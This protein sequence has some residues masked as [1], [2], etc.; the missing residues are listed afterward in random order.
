[1]HK[2]TFLLLAGD[3]FSPNIVFTFSPNFLSLQNSQPHSNKFPGDLCL[4]LALF[5]FQQCEVH[6][7]IIILM[8]EGPN[9][10]V[11]Y[12]VK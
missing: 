5:S 11:K 8:D 4:A 9:K 10:N 1:M 12:S 7:N 3:L 2:I 6:A